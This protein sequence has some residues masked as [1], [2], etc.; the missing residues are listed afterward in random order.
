MRVCFWQGALE[1]HDHLKLKGF[2]CAKL[3]D[4]VPELEGID[5]IAI[6]E[7]HFFPDVGL[8]VACMHAQAARLTCHL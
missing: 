3:F 6:D 4:A 7:G 5:V 2:S 8:G 1:T